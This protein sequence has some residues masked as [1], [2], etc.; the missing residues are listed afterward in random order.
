MPGSTKNFDVFTATYIILHYLTVKWEILPI[1]LNISDLIRRFLK[2]PTQRTPSKRFEADSNCPIAPPAM[3]EAQRT[4]RF[5]SFPLPGD[6]G[7]GKTPVGRRRLRKRYNLV[8]RR[9]GNFC[10]TAACPPSLALRQR[11]AGLPVRQKYN[12][13]VP[14]ACRV[15]A[16]AKPGASV[17]NI[18]FKTTLTRV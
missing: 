13:S 14:A 17:V 5:F 9:A 18:F 3:L 11:R 10:R 7:K 2:G 16:L 15:V 6:D 1:W 12:L 4:L 8:A